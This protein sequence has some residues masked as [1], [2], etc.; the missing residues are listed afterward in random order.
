[1]VKWYGYNE[2]LYRS[3]STSDYSY[4]GIAIFSELNRQTFFL[5]A[6]KYSNMCRKIAYNVIIYLRFFVLLSRLVLPIN[7]TYLYCISAPI[8][9]WE[10]NFPPF[11]DSSNGKWRKHPFFGVTN[12]VKWSKALH[13]LPCDRCCTRFEFAKCLFH[14]LGNYERPTTGRGLPNS[15]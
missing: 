3:I 11:E 12:M 4:K 1:M 7:A 10:C 8:G 2:P 13:F 6:R 9:A 14:L 15:I 5:T